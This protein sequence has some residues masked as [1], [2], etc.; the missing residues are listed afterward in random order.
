MRMKK[1]LAAVLVLML[2]VAILAGCSG[3]GSGIVGK[4][5]TPEME[6]MN[7]EYYNFTDDGKV[8]ALGQDYGT[9]TYE[10]GTLKILKIDLDEP[11]VY[12][13]VFEDDD[14]MTMTQKEPI[15]LPADKLI[16]MK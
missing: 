15:E 11:N 2:G 9:Y 13:V 4:W 3:S 16:R 5:T 6:A 7:V 8:T 14:H 1:G 12:E 10:N